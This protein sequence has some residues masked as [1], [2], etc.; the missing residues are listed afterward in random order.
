M[1]VP[2][3]RVIALKGFKRPVRKRDLCA[4][5]GIVGYC[6]RFNLSYTKWTDTLKKALCKEVPNLIMWDDRKIDY[7]N[8][9][10]SVLCSSSVVWLPKHDDHFVLHTNASFQGVSAVLFAV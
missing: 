4:F 6:H 1:V 9:L 3:A 5:L 7:F 2:E 10:I 8:H